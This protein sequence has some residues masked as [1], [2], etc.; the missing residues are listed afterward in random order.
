LHVVTPSGWI[1]LALDPH[2][3]QPTKE[4][5][6][7]RDRAIEFYVV[8]EWIVL[9]AILW[10]PEATQQYQVWIAAFI[11]FEIILNL[12]SIVFVGKLPSIY[13]PTA[14]IERSLILFGINVSQVVIAFA[15]FYRVALHLSPKKAVLTATLVFGTLGSPSLSSEN[16][17][18]IVVVLQVVT[19]FLLIAIF[20]G[21]FV[22]RLGAFRR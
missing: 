9:C 6:W 1:K 20:L 22:G 8:V 21:A 13:P 14:S 15:I 2:T 4:E 5:R 17:A 7:V 3:N 12:S 10:V 18:A 19:D 16:S 11:L